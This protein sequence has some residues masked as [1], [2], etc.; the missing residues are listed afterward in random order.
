MGRPEPRSAPAAER[1]RLTAAL[2]DRFS[3]G[4]PPIDLGWV[5]TLAQ[6]ALRADVALL[7]V[8]DGDHQ[9]FLGQRGLEHTHPALDSTPVSQSLCRFVVERDAPLVVHDTAR[10]RAFAQHPATTELGVAAYAGVPLRGPDGLVLGALCALGWT[11]RIWTSQDLDDLDALAVFVQGELELAA[12]RHADRPL[13][14]TRATPPAPAL[15]GFPGAGAVVA[16]LQTA[17]KDHPHGGLASVQIDRFEE[18]VTP[19][20]RG[21]AQRLLARTAA[22]LSATLPDSALLAYAGGGH[23]L[24]LLSTP[25]EAVVAQDLESELRRALASP[26][27]DP[28]LTAAVGIC[29]GPFGDM[30]ATELV[31]RAEAAAVPLPDALTR[32]ELASTGTPRRIRPGIATQIVDGLARGEFALHYQPIVELES[33][34][35]TAYEALL[36]WEDPIRGLVPPP[37]FL[38]SAE[39]VGVMPVLTRFVV[40]TACAQLQAWAA[41]GYR[42][43]VTINGSPRE[44]L[45]PGFPALLQGQLAA[46]GV[47]PT[48]LVV[49]LTEAVTDAGPDALARMIAA[50]AD[51]GVRTALDD[52]GAE[53]SGLRRLRALPI[54]FLKIDRRYL[55]GVPDDPRAC[56]IV[57]AVAALGRAVGASVV[58]EGVETEAQHDF[59]RTHGC[60]HGQG[61]YYGRP[62]AGGDGAPPHWPVR[63]PAP[64]P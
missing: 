2:T 16:A 28:P 58:A 41:R 3:A 5:A 13:A 52:F 62:A 56:A 61:W 32:P 46:T 30:T 47:D 50:L 45:D 49:E 36:R 44:V 17:S 37:M 23:F 59:A 60:R 29:T 22:R 54:D 27:F 8:L 43:G 26:E 25:D 57:D 53:H 10:D 55:D 51:I 48:L 38:P 24:A 6:R 39:R 35:I 33:G 4:L 20:G 9:H 12:R 42:V 63:T 7:T 19:L 40:Q 14:R 18:L 11:P 34:R 31:D 1:A 21:G 64:G 15:I